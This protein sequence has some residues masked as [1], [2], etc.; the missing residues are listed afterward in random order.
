MRFKRV[1]LLSS[2][3][4]FRSKFLFRS[5]FLFRIILL[6]GLAV[7]SHQEFNNFPVSPCPNVFLYK[8][9]GQEWHGEIKIP[10]SAI[11]Q[12]QSN[13]LKVTF[14]LRASQNVSFSLVFRFS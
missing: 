8:Y 5:N 10:T 11:L 7:N 12:Q 14:T 1:T 6:I 9:D 3:F 2:T 4:W 13:M